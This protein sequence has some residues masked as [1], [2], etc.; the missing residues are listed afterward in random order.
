MSEI[1]RLLEIMAQLRDPE[2][3]CAWDVKQTFATIA[4]YTIEEAYEVADAIE[5][6]D[7]TDLRDELGDLLLQV[8]FHARMAEEAGEFNF[9]DVA[10]SI[11][12]GFDWTS[13]EPV[14]EKV[15]EELAEVLQA[16]E[17]QAA[18]EIVEEMGDL[19]F[20]AVNLSRHLNVDPEQALRRA[21]LKF[22]QRFNQVERLAARRGLDMHSTSID[23]LDKLWEE[24]KSRV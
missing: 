13:L 9:S 16:H 22:S 12:A 21:T 11:N 2:S 23:E 8:V 6:H 17:Q 19:L 14:V 10:S 5:R 7:L 20:A 4:P 18:T 24:V 1:D 15:E 3:G